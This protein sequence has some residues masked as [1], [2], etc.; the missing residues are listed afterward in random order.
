[1]FAEVDS[2]SLGQPVAEP[3]NLLRIGALTHSTGNE[4]VSVWICSCYI[5]ECRYQAIRIFL[6]HISS[7]R[8][9]QK[10]MFKTKP[11]ARLRTIYW[12]A[13]CFVKRIR[14]RNNSSAVET[15]ITTEVL[16][17]NELANSNNC[18][19]VPAS[20][21]LFIPVRSDRRRNFMQGLNNW[22]SQSV[23]CFEDPLRRCVSTDY[24]GPVAGEPL[25]TIFGQCF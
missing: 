5:S 13:T 12:R 19:N 21:R 3:S 6:H 1:M 8:N 17:P 11:R 4:Q 16:P 15:G 22:N 10:F 14:N 20:C 2:L 9:E 25:T 18:S 24:I 7:K 23:S